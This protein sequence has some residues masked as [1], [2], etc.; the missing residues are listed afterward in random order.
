VWAIRFA[1][2]DYLLP[3]IELGAARDE[4]KVCQAAKPLGLTIPPKPLFMA[5]EVI[6]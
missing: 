4:P 3:N 5:D 6:E 2:T 1:S